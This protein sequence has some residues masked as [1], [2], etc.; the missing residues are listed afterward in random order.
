[1][2]L[3]YLTLME[4]ELRVVYDLLQNRAPFASFGSESI[5]CLWRR[6]ETFVVAKNAR[7]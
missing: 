2:M 7:L 5:N 4:K 3:A 6:L 1:M